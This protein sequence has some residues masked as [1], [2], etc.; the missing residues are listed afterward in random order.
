VTEHWIEIEGPEGQREHH[1]E[2]ELT[3]IG[4]AGADVVLEGAPR[5]ELHLWND[6]PKAVW[7]GGE[8]G[9]LLAGTKLD[10]HHLAD[11]DRIAWADWSITFHEAGALAVLEEVHAEPARSG[12]SARVPEAW[13][14]VKAGVLVEQ[15]LAD[16]QVAKRW[17]DA[18]IR[19]D[20]QA[21]ACAR[22]LLADNEV[23]DDHPRV[24]ERSSRLLRDLL[25][26]PLQRGASGASRKARVATK[27]TMAAAVAQFIIVGII[28]G[29]TFVAMVLSRL[30]WGTSFDGW[31][32][33]ILGN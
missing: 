22:E 21:E 8:G 16:K 5:G 27:N 26:T 4:G 31:I 19:G 2:R 24:V 17:S 12:A 29:M 1:L 25:M 32:D 20:F 7:L 28:L 14:R 11:G 18:V 13:M 15:G 9:P 6:P 33:A 10:E 30:K 23:P 3:R